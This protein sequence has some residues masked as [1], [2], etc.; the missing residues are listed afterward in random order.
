MS[1]IEQKNVEHR[2][3]RRGPL[4]AVRYWTFFCSIFDIQKKGLY[5]KNILKTLCVEP[6]DLRFGEN[7]GEGYLST[8]K[9]SSVSTSQSAFRGSK[10]LIRTFSGW[11]FL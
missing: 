10:T 3:T 8:E 6:I 4:R 1:N 7:L 5:P 11:R 2:R 9:S